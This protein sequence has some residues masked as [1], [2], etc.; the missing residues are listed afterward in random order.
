[1]T[2][3]RLLRCLRNGG[4]EIELIVPVPASTQRAV[5]AVLLI[6]QALA[7]LGKDV[8]FVHCIRTTREP[9]KQLKNVNGLEERKKLLEGLYTVNPAFDA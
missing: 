3:E 6:G 8:R 7:K 2:V 9:A 5:S 4:P 1:M